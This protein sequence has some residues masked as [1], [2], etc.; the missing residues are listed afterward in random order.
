MGDKQETA[1]LARWPHGTLISSG[2]TTYFSG[3]VSGFWILL[4]H[5]QDRS[6]EGKAEIIRELQRNTVTILVGE[7]GSGKTTRASS[8]HIPVHLP[9]IHAKRYPSTFSRQGYRAGNAL[10]S[11]NRDGLLLHLLR[12]AFPRNKGFLWVHL[13]D[14]LFALTSV[15][16]RAR[17]SNS[18]QMECWFGN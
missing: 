4:S 8:I 16:A 17:R 10:R 3:Y 18:S 15:A 2:G 14:I 6:I 13:S 11:P 12:P 5:E 1:I 7:T 9:L